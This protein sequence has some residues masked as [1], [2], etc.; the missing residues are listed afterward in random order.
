MTSLVL[1]LLLLAAE[2]STGFT[3]LDW[4]D[5]QLRERPE[6]CP[7]RIELPLPG[8]FD[9]RSF[10]KT[11]EKPRV[12]Q[13]D[14]SY[15]DK[16]RIRAARGKWDPRRRT[17]ETA[18]DGYDVHLLADVYLASGI[19]RIVSVR[20]QLLVGG[21]EVAEGAEEFEADEGAV[22]WEDGVHLFVPKK[23]AQGRP[24]ALRAEL[25]VGERAP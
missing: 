14:G 19:D 17:V 21:V 20:Y 9:G 8:L 24:I 23:A 3:V 6:Q 12:V 13:C 22:N 10:R 16:L 25:L 15:F 11:S 18:D 2:P 4:P 7:V 1:T 5:G